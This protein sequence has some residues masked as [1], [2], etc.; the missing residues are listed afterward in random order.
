MAGV[1]GVCVCVG[2]LSKESTE[3]FLSN[4]EAISVIK[5]AKWW[6]RTYSACTRTRTLG[7]QVKTRKAIGYQ[8]R[9]NGPQEN[10]A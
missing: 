6:R 8:G 2:F 5:E 3:W 4:S 7:Y 10:L 9:Q 1:G